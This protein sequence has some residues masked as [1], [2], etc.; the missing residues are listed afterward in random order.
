MALQR[1][2]AVVIGAGIIGSSIAVNLAR[3]GLSVRL[4]DSGTLG[5][6]ASSAGAGI[7][8]PGGEFA[9]D[10]ILASLA[11]ESLRIYPQYIQQLESETGLRIDFGV[12]GSLHFY[13]SAGERDTAA[14][15]LK[16][17]TGWGIHCELLDDAAFYPD[18]AFVDPTEVLKALR[19]SIESRG[20]ELRENCR[21]EEIESSEAGAVVIAAGAWSSQIRV[22]NGGRRIQLQE[23]I[24]VKGH[25]IGYRMD[26]GSLGPVRWHDHSYVVQRGNGFTIAGSTEERVG[27]DR[28][29]DENICRG[30][31][32]RAVQLWPRLRDETPVRSWIGFRPATETMHVQIGRVPETN[33][34]LAYG[35][36]RNGILLAPI[37]ARDIAAEIISSLGK[38]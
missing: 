5:G 38:G 8:A 13:Y 34:W 22:S 15:R 31:H 10:P 3:A 9:H 1:P 11:V 7:L 19:C 16:R 14:E 23:S 32:E 35:H 28:H 24:P 26:P 18:D 27:F 33:V 2:D 37:T 6:E 12:C 36:Y 21:V 29:V 17:H 30:L 20:L 4:I 25:L